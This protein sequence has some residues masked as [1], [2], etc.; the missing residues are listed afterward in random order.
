MKYIWHIRWALPAGL[1]L[2]IGWQTFFST[3]AITATTNFTAR[4]K[5]FDILQPAGR[6]ERTASGIAL[7]AEP[8]YIDVRLPP[9]TA[10][11]T[12]KL[13]TTAE[14]A[15]LQLGVKQGN[16]FE[17][18]FK[19]QEVQGDSARRYSLRA[20]SFPYLEPGR[21][22]RFIIS[23][24]RFK[25]GDITISGAEVE[26]VRQGFSAAWLKRVFTGI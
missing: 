24:P 14:S 15:P 10:A 22:L 1:G 7:Q 19:G 5:M 3:A 9:R 6:V 26:V 2:F 25:P 11:V 18:L 12:L 4:T 13:G 23:A 20:T 17:Y 8:V 16:N 21:R